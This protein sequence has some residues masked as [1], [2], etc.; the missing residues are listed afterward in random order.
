MGS[1]CRQTIPMKYHTLFVI[2]EKSAKF[3]LCRLMQIIGGT[4]WVTISES[5]ANIISSPPP[6]PNLCWLNLLSFLKL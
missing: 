5:T 3:T 1:V 4:L 2:F 6:P